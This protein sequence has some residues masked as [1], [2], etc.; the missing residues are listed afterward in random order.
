MSDPGEQ[1]SF[2]TSPPPQAGERRFVQSTAGYNVFTGEE[3]QEEETSS[4]SLPEASDTERCVH[5][6]ANANI[7]LTGCFKY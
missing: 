6:V 1:Q 4:E 3:L 2:T 7:F 5:G